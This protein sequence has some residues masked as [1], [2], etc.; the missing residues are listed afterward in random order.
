MKVDFLTVLHNRLAVDLY[1]LNYKKYKNRKIQP[2]FKVACAKEHNDILPTEVQ[3][4]EYERIPFQGSIDHAYN[5]HTLLN[6]VETEWFCVIDPDV[7]PVSDTWDETISTLMEKYEL[8]G[9]R[10]TVR[11]QPGVS[12]DFPCTIL[13]FYKKDVF[14]EKAKKH[15]LHPGARPDH[16]S[17][18]FPMTKQRDLDQIF[19]YME[20]NN[21]TLSRIEEIR[22]G[23]MILHPRAHKNS[24]WNEHRSLWLNGGTE[25]K[26]F[27]CDTGWKTSVIFK[28]SA[29]YCFN[30]DYLFKHFGHGTGGSNQ[31]LKLMRRDRVRLRYAREVLAAYGKRIELNTQNCYT[32][33]DGTPLIKSGPLK[34]IRKLEK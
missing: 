26:N 19:D 21:M 28:D 3:K 31:G 11:N 27:V 30:D 7:Y 2:V 16:W 12:K 15:G 29:Y 18:F 4:F 25:H 14:F 34:N 22:G 9:M 1:N 10:H 33:P 13:S 32:G 5:L 6:H 20:L 23:D 24:M 8:I 17:I